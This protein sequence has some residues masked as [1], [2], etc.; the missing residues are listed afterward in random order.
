M[1]LILNPYPFSV[2]LFFNEVEY[3]EECQKRDWKDMTFIEDGEWASVQ[4]KGSL[5]VVRFSEDCNKMTTI[6]RAGVVSH[7]MMHVLQQLQEYICEDEPGRE[8]QAYH[9]QALVEYC[10]DEM[11][12]AY[13][14]TVSPGIS[15]DTPGE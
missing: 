13:T 12:K 1:E 7:E 8:F 11:E 4:T 14:P 9:L 3:A 2:M 15:E 6:K 10:L 5:A